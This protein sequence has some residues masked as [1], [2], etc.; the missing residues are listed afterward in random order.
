[1]HR[2]RSHDNQTIGA[3]IFSSKYWCAEVNGGTH[4]GSLGLGRVDRDERQRHAIL[5]REDRACKVAQALRPCVAR[6]AI[7]GKDRVDADVVFDVLSR[8][9]GG[10]SVD[11]AE[12]PTIKF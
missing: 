4:S 11:V 8:V 6:K 10:D 7:V 2:G 9:G 5:V 3:Q 1:M 12:G